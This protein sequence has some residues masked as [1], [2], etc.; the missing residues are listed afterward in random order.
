MTAVRA[1]RTRVA[2]A[3]VTVAATAVGTLAACTGDGPLPVSTAATA[4][5]ATVSVTSTPTTTV[6]PEPSVVTG[7]HPFTGLDVPR[8]PVLAV[9]VD[10][11]AGARPQEGVAAADLV[12]VEE[13]EGGLTRL[14]AVFSSRLPAQV[15]PVRS[16]RSSDVAI[17]GNR[18]PV[19]LA[20][21]GANAGVLAQVDASPL[22]PIGPGDGYRR[23]PDRRA[24]Y[25][26]MV[27]PAAVLTRDP[28]PTPPQDIGV[29]FGE[30]PPGGAAAARAAYAWPAATIAFDWDTGSG[31]WVQ[32]MDGEVTTGTGA[33]PHEAATVVFQAVTVRPSGYVDASGAPSP[34]VVPV[35]TGEAVVLR[36]GRSWR[37]TWTRPDAASPT[38]FR[39]ET[40]GV[41]PFAPGPVWVVLIAA[42]RAPS[43]E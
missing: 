35:G 14:A 5:S 42:G 29:V 8:G 1:A 41:L 32:N 10:N 13:V 30:A 4:P 12:Y 21:S 11:T 39:T 16:A 27:D 6:T 28:D 3:L 37:A 2:T 17:L 9:K 20:F 36:D 19:A 38:R 26:L 15:G 25:D 23:D 18:G 24:P 40:G 7:G 22:Q 31:R 43:V 34:E 33:P